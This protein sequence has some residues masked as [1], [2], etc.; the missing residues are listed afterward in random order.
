M[1]I[2]Y[3]IMTHKHG[4]L[5][6]ILTAHVPYLRAAGR[7]PQGEDALH[8]TIAGAIIPVLNALFDLSDAGAGVPV[9]FGYSPVLLE[10]LSD[11]VVQK[12][13][14]L[15]M[16]EWLEARADALARWERQGAAHN[17]YLGRFYLDW[18]R[19]VLRSFVE[20]YGRNP[21][22]ALRELCA[23]GAEP[24]AGAATH[25]YLPLL[26]QAG[27]LYAQIDVGTFSTNRHLGRRPSGF[28]L[29]ECGYHPALLSPLRD[30]KLRYCIVDPASMDESDTPQMLPRWVIPGQLAALAREQS[31]TEQAWSPELGYPGDPLYRSPRRDPRSRLELWRN[32]T[33]GTPLTLYDPYD[34]FQRAQSHAAHFVSTVVAELERFYA[35]TKQPG[36]ALITLDAEL[37]GRR[38]FEGP[39]WLRAVLE[40]VANEQTIQ[41]SIPS[42]YLRLQRPRQN[43][44][45]QEGSWGIGGD[46]RAWN[47]AA[48]RPIWQ[49]I[50]EAEERL[51][52]LAHAN[53]NAHG[54]RERVLNQ[55]LRELLLA[56]SSDWPLLLSQGLT[57][58]PL[59][60]VTSHLERCERLCRLAEAETLTAQALGYLA[61]IEE[62][63]NPFPYL[64]YRIVIE[65]GS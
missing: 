42:E 46:H 52:A 25:A 59:R 7:H 30:S 45:L 36:L 19:G 26:S 62:L 29:P 4:Y 27:S 11:N 22:A 55:A 17:S 32:G 40:R 31:A 49:A 1:V 28:W 13:F 61:E 2:A 35:Q 51:I 16:E 58:E 56:Q 43:I 57:D 20:R 50:S 44:V 34:A 10:Q 41:L 12:H 60:R 15:W 65:T 5:G 63:D 18:G 33:P 54:E 24:L 38:W 9:A 53:P 6:I 48:A 64:N 47:G 8:E 23:R 3:Y 39:M 14:V 21:T 37:L